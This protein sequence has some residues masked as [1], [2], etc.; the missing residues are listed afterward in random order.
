MVKIFADLMK[1]EPRSPMSRKH[2]K[3]EENHTK[4]HI[5]IKLFK[6]NDKI[7]K[8]SEEKKCL[9]YRRAKIKMTVGFSWETMQTV[10]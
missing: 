7:L 10:E 2:K 4:H 5:I 1:G 8:Q 6:S 9:I 3:R